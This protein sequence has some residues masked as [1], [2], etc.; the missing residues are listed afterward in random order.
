MRKYVFLTLLLLTLLS[1]SASAQPQRAL[2]HRLI[3]N[4]NNRVSRY[5]APRFRDKYKQPVPL[6]HIYI[7]ERTTILFDNEGQFFYMGSTRQ[8]KDGR[9]FPDGEGICRTV[10]TSMNHSSYEY[11]L[12]PWKRGSRNGE[13]IL[14]LPDGTFRKAVWKWDRLKS[15]SDETPTPEEIEKMENEIARMEQI[16]KLL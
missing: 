16:L 12:C 13:G 8:L 3:A 1:L 7:D 2:E 6:Q 5:Q 4:Q 10:R 14:K 9:Q 15:T 11:C